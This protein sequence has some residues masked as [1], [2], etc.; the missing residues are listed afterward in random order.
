MKRER[1]SPSEFA[2]GVRTVAGRELGAIFDSGIATI[3]TV[4]VV[5]LSNWVFMNDFFLTGT[6]D[7]TPFF[8]LQPWLLAVY[9]P[10]IT[11]RSWAEE[12]RQRTL[13]LLLTLPLQSGQAVLGKF[14]ASLGLFALYVLGSL[15]IVLMLFCLGDPDPGLLLA[16]YLGLFA[17]GAFFLALGMFFSALSAD[18]IVAFVVSTVLSFALV[19]LGWEQAVSALDGWF[20]GLGTWAYESLSMA[21]HYEAFLRGAVDLASL[22]Y[23]GLFTA[24]LLWAGALVLDEYRA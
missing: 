1:L 7:M 10:A 8:E 15:P 3:V 9:L 17:L 5:V 2:S 6:V 13:E 4:A 22:L 21:P 23:F 18:Q 16:S 14:L 20:D 11:M 12:R 24:L 19:L